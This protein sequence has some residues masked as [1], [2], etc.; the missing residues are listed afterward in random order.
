MKKLLILFLLI[1]PL[2]GHGQSFNNILLS[3]RTTTPTLYNGQIWYDATTNKVKVREGGVTK[4]AVGGGAGTVTSVNAS[5]GT[6]GLTFSGGPI[7]SSGTLTLGGTLAIANGGTGSSSFPGF[8]LANGGTATG[9]NTKTFNTASW[10]NISQ[11]WT[12]T[13]NNQYGSR[14]TYNLTSRA[15]ASDK[16]DPFYINS[17]I[18]A[19][20]TS[21]NG[22]GLTVESLFNVVGGIST[23][24]ALGQTG[25]VT[26]M[27][28]NTYTGVSATSTSGSGTGAVFTVVVT[29]ATTI[30]TVTVTTAG[31]NYRA[32][33]TVTFNGSLFG[34]S[35]SRIIPISTVTGNSF[36]GESV[37]KLLHGMPNVSAQTRRYLDFQ[38]ITSYGGTPTTLHS[39][40]LSG[41]SDF[42]WIGPSG[43]ILTS[44]GSG[45][46]VIPS[47]T[48][49]ALTVGSG[50][51]LAATGIIT[52]SFGLN[53]GNTGAYIQAGV[54]SPF[55]TN[56][57]SSY[58]ANGTTLLTSIFNLGTVTGGSGYTNG[59][60]NNTPLTGGSG[61]GATANITVAG[62]VVTTAIISQRGS[63]YVA[64]ESLSAS[65]PG[66]SGFSVLI[67]TIS[68]ATTTSSGFWSSRTIN[69]PNSA[70]SWA[71]FRAQPTFNQTGSAT[72]PLYGYWYSP[73]RIS[74][75]GTEYAFRGDGGITFLANAAGDIPTPGTRFGVRGLSGGTNI[76]RLATSANT[77]R[78][79]FKDAGGLAVG[80]SEGTSGQVLT[81]GGAG[82]PVTW[83]TVGGGGALSSLSAAT[84]TNDIDNLNNAQ[85]WRWNTLSG[86]GIN[87]IST[88]TAAAS[89]AQ[90]LLTVQVDG[91][92]SNSSQTT[93]AGWF[94][95]FHTGTSSKNVALS[96]EAA[97]G[98]T[99]VGLQVLN[100]GIEFDD[101]GTNNIVFGTTN[102]TRLGTATTQKIGFYN[103]T[104]VV[105]QDA[106]TTSQGIADALTAYGLL[107]SS[108]ISA[109]TSRTIINSQ[110]VV[111]DANITAA[112][113]VSY[114]AAANIFSTARTIDVSALNTD[115]DYIEIYLDTQ[116]SNLSFTG[117]SVYLADNT[118][119]VTNLLVRANYQIR[120]KNG[121]LY[122]IN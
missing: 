85:T 4:D 65:I 112:A 66:G 96:V 38:G 13:G 18:T 80:G 16:I 44:T 39:F 41:L 29:N 71:E 79:A 97:T 72:G 11:T 93:R 122:I 107:P 27:T 55:I 99:N 37:V 56:Q 109:T 21:I 90:Q 3:P 2:L 46:S 110:T 101:G 43:N 119:T 31:S 24:S 70:S 30:S 15:S 68:N 113:G 121:R 116:T 9:A 117:A 36:S 87:L 62:G 28:A 8:L 95:N 7:A 77:E 75:I 61:T 103:A 22:S 108:T 32:G 84:G 81:S 69:D 88:S 23:M 53:G 120:R 114:F 26:G 17:S 89:N 74:V 67:A 118:T 76:A 82:S 91:A 19:A 1:A 64:G 94:R 104:P 40:N 25:S 14:Y 111:T 34:G 105:R 33:E 54:I 5:G 20:S 6:T 58:H 49:A 42:V 47:L 57:T 51:A 78:F 59:T 63:G 92:N 115:N 73:N 86:V 83:T 106:V 60:Y 100:G 102:G 48:T 35:G 10:D 12:A 45:V 50:A 52:N 98:T